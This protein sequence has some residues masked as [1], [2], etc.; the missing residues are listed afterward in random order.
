MANNKQYRRKNHQAVDSMS[1]SF[2]LE[3]GKVVKLF[4]VI[5]LVFVVFYFLTVYIL[6]KGDSSSAI[7]DTTPAEADIQYQEILAGN[8]FSMR[9]DHYYVLYYDMS[10]DDLKSTY[11]N[12]VSTYEDKD[13]HYAIYT[14]D[15]SSVFN[16][17]YVSGTA[18]SDVQDVDYLRV[19]G[20]TLIEFENGRAVD[21][22]EGEDAITQELS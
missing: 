7:V 5:I 13:D 6:E 4:I 11:T 15:M 1:S 18:N 17:Q 20:P 3:V 16:K 12:I 14:A 22:I 21:Y 9:D 19:A 2:S 8:S 10:S